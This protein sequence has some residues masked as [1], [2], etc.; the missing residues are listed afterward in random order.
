MEA[1]ITGTGPGSI[2]EAVECYVEFM[3]KPLKLFVEAQVKVPDC[4]IHGADIDF[5]LVRV[6]SLAR[7][8]LIV[9]N[10]SNLQLH[11]HLSCPND[12]V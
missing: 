11:W 1:L 12:E 3:D 8:S 10:T 5:N 7:A 9:E 2:A 4:I 6:G